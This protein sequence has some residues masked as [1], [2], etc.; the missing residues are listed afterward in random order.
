MTLSVLK[1]APETSTAKNGIADEARQQI[2]EKLSSILV[3]NYV[4]TLK[5]HLYHWNIV[6]PTFKS[7]HDLTEEHYED[8]FEASDDLA[9]RVRAL[10]HVVPVGEHSLELS[11]TAASP[12]NGP[13]VGRNDDFRP[14]RSARF[15]RCVHARRR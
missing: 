15:D 10:G 5:S 1:P 12:G 9:E 11:L 14:C 6:G 13:A 3:D 4:L 8:L 7:I 2:A